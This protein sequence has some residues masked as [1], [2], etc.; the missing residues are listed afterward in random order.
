MQPWLQVPLPSVQ[1]SEL[2]LPFFSFSFL[3]S[4]FLRPASEGRPKYVFALS[5]FPSLLTL[6]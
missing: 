6:F 2:K 4:F 5:F 3:T 1:Y